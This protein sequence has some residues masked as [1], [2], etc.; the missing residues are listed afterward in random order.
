MTDTL[1]DFGFREIRGATP[2]SHEDMEVYGNV[3]LAIAGA[4]GEISAREWEFLEGLAR[5]LGATDQLIQKWRAFDYKKANLESLLKHAHVKTRRRAL[6]YDA[7]RVSRADGVYAKEERAA[8]ARA[9]KTLG[10]DPAVVA[11]IEGLVEME[12]SLRNMRSS[13]LYS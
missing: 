2:P 12:T 9:A 3:L 11:A 5:S 8:A 6:L 1:K 13:L 10:V 4:D 7:I